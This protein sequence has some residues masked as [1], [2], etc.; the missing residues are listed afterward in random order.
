[1]HL[2]GY[3]EHISNAGNRKQVPKRI[4]LIKMGW[5]QDHLKV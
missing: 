4:A 3:A 5:T 1:M 2:L